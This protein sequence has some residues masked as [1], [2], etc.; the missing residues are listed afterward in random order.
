MGQVTQE[1]ESLSEF[2]VPREPGCPFD[3]PA[4][5]EAFREESGI[6]RVRLWNDQTAW[7]ITRASYFRELLADPR[8][9]ANRSTPG[10]PMTSRSSQAKL[11]TRASFRMM[12][13]DD[14]RRLR[15]MVNREFTMPSVEASR[16]LIQQ[17]CDDLIDEMIDR[18]PTADLIRDYAFGL[19]TT[20]ICHILGVSV[21]R[22]DFF[23]H[24]IATMF[25]R[26][27]DPSVA[28]AA[29]KGLITYLTELVEEV[30]QQ[31]PRDN[32]VSRLVHQQYLP[33]KIDLPDLLNTFVQLIAGGFD[34]TGNGIGSGIHLLLQHPEQLAALRDSDD[35]KFVAAAI[36]ELL[37]YIPIID[38]GFDRVVTDDIELDGHLI[39]AGDGLIFNVPAA[40]RDPRDFANANSVDICPAETPDH[41]AFGSGPHQC[42]GQNLARVEL[43]VAIPTL[44]RR[45]PGLAHAVPVEDVE[46]R[47]DRQIVG[48]DSLPISWDQEAALALRGA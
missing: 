22:R 20:L 19:P 21:E 39:R 38:T 24:A 5:Y 7:L 43:R 26:D 48:L 10:M 28:E 8:V 34:T 30:G 47:F 27:T 9:S 4:A 15:R 31:E 3:P 41:V 2:P 11:P 46:W 25:N 13:G 40:N 6:T 18:G 23:E 35:P 36:E 44:L 17:I 37:R 16:E 12:D 32:V 14:H 1:I 42:L 33:G 45:L 29:G